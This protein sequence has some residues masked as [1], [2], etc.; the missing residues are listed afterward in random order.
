MKKFGKRVFPILLAASMIISSA[1]LENLALNAIAED[2]QT[3]VDSNFKDKTRFIITHWHADGTA[4]VE[5]DDTKALDASSYSSETVTAEPYD[6]E[7]FVGY[8]VSAGAEAVTDLMSSDPTT[9]PCCTINYNGGYTS[10]R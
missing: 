5:D 7:T 10:L 6:N 8:S 1:P 2:Y 3:A 4:V 9:Q